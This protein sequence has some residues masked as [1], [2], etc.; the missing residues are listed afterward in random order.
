MATNRFLEETE[1]YRMLSDL[2]THTVFSHGKGEI[3][4]NILAA[5]NMNLKEIAITDHGPGHLNYGIKRESIPVMREQVDNL[6]GIHQREIKVYLGVEANIVSE[7]NGLDILPEEMK[8]FDF[9]IAG[10]HYGI[11]GGY[12]VKNWVENHLPLT[13]PFG[14]NMRMLNTAMTINALYSNDIK[15]LS[16]PGDKGQFDIPA[17]AKACLETGTLMEINTWHKHLSVEDLRLLK[18][19]ENK[20]I[21]SSDAH[22]PDRVGDFKPG[23]ARAL[24]AGIEP[25]RIVNI[26][27]F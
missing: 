4:D 8:D 21:I 1:K 11:H 5:I 6:A 13:G 17:I 22:S 15:I 16:H 14:K 12:T 9:L 27:R 7:G 10:Y 23:L 3:E 20:F 24:E 26:T 19:T 2:H 18:K 25:E